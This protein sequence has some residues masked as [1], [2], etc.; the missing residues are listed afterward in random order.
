[1]LE[2]RGRKKKSDPY[3]GPNEEAAVVRFL[4]AEDMAEKSK[5]YKEW[6][7]KPII[8]MVESIIRRYKL[9]RK[10]FTFE[11]TRDDAISY[12]IWKSNK[13]EPDLEKKAY[14]YY[15]TICRNYILGLI[16][17]DAKVFKKTASFEDSYPSIEERDDLIYHLSDS[18]YAQEDL[19]KD[20]S[21]QI[22]DELN[23]NLSD[24]KKLTE[25]ER[26]VGEAL[27]YLLDNWEM[28]FEGPIV[29]TDGSPMNCMEHLGGAKYNKNIILATIRDY[30]NLTTK[31][32]RV[33]IRRFKSLYFL[34]KET[35]IK[36]GYL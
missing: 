25:N 18:E 35:K 4:E 29:D 2:T 17:K 13:F 1:M 23:G 32:I 5:I 10:G 26:K 19:I 9:Y 20:M 8:K 14:S 21:N 24:K 28:I 34:F 22:K 15:G 36:G 12:I 11:E 3:F 27:I 7:E 16:Q 6:L 30:T 31:D 33:S